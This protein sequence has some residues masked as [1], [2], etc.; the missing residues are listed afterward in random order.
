MCISAER[1]RGSYLCKRP[2]LVGWSRSN[3]KQ[4]TSA[5]PVGHWTQAAEEFG[6]GEFPQASHYFL[7]EDC[8]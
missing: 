6:E 7:T 5:S 2:P 3:Q 8:F 4:L 1:R